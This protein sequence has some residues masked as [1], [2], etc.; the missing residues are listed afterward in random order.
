VLLVYPYG[1][2]LCSLNNI[3]IV[4]FWCLLNVISRRVELELLALDF[5]L[6]EYPTKSCLVFLYLLIWYIK[7]LGDNPSL[8]LWCFG[9][10]CGI[11]NGLANTVEDIILWFGW[12][13]NCDWQRFHPLG[14]LLSQILLPHTI[15]WL[16]TLNIF[17]DQCEWMGLLYMG[18]LWFPAPFF[19][20]PLMDITSSSNGG[21]NIGCILE[22][23]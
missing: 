4:C 10:L 5:V 7:D 23:V 1:K 22:R 2:Y 13:Q 11:I 17:V 19:M 16:G 14:Q 12:L 9:E 8:C 6:L 15:L 18:I 20:F 3:V 21:Y